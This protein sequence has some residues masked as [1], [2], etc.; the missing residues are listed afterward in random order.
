M[1]ISRRSSWQSAATHRHGKYQKM[2]LKFGSNQRALNS[3][4][5][6]INSFLHLALDCASHPVDQGTHPHLSLDPYSSPIQPSLATMQESQQ[7][8]TEDFSAHIS[9][10]RAPEESSQQGDLSSDPC[11]SSYIIEHPF[12]CPRHFIHNP[13]REALSVSFYR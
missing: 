4:K 13:A 11:Y 10:Q 7:V 6:H 1:T 12:L 5:T 3:T 2:I 8:A 9:E